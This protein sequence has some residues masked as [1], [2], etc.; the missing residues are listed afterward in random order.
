MRIFLRFTTL[1]GALL[2]AMWALPGCSSDEQAGGK[3]EGGAMDKG[4]MEGGAMDKGKMEGGA[5]DKGKMEG[6]AMDKGKM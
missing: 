3:M 2:M 4:K 6:G 1:T 5:M